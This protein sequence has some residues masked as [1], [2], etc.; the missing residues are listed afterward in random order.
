MI[1]VRDTVRSRSLPIATLLLIG[2][3]AW[4]FTREITAGDELEKLI[5]HWALFPGIYTR[6]QAFGSSILAPARYVPMLTSM[7]LHGGWMHILGNMLYLW[8]FGGHVE[9]MLGHVRFFTFYVL[10]GFAAALTQIWAD[11]FSM[12]PIVGASGAIAG[13][14]GGYFFLFPRARIVTLIPIIIIPWF[15]ELP[16]FVFLGVWFA[17]QLLNG[18]AGLGVT[19]ESGGVAW[20]AHAGGF[21]AGFV[22]VILLPK[23]TPRRRMAPGY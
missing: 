2:L 20:W 7:F 21:V 11:P 4:A 13:V 16:A 10:C 14:L 17:M 23:Q 8:V 1:P 15:V 19:T 18:T 12:T 9:D 22:L 6:W 5:R 3:N